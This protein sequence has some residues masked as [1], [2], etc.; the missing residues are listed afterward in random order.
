MRAELLHVEG[1]TAVTILQNL[2]DVTDVN[3]LPPHSFEAMVLGGDND[4][5]GQTIWDNQPLGIGSVGAVP[6]EVEDSQDGDQTVRFS[7]PTVI[8]VYVAIDLVEVD[9]DDFG[10]AYDDVREAVRAGAE[11]PGQASFLGI[12]TDV[13]ASRINRDAM[14]VSGVIDSLTGVSL[15]A[16][17]APGVGL[18]RLPVGPREIA[19]IDTGDIFMVG[20]E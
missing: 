12:G 7:R 16:I 17:V 8:R 1:V 3:G 9:A 4:D 2:S 13:I 10:D 11:T 15:T 6:V 19:S 18:T 20:E 5:I 14:S